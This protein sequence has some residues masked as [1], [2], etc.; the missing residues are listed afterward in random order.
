VKDNENSTV[1]VSLATLARH[2]SD[3]PRGE[4]AALR[5]AFE[6]Q[7][8]SIEARLEPNAYRPAIDATV[9]IISGAFDER[10]EELA[11]ALD[12][13]RVQLVDLQEQLKR[14]QQEAKELAAE[15][16]ELQRKLKDVTSAKTI[17]ETQYQQLV[18]ASQQLT[19]GLS[20]ALH[21]QREQ[22]RPV[23]PPVP[24]RSESIA[25]DV[26]PVK[27]MPSVAAAAAGAKKKPLQFS[28]TARDAK[29]VKIRRG[30]HLSVDGIPGELVDLSLGGAQA[31]LR[32]MVK[33]NQLVRMILPTPT[34]QLVCR[35]RI[36]WVVYE[37]PGTSLS[38]YRMGVKFTDIDTKAVEDFMRDFREVSLSESEQSSDIA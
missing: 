7:I 38:V 3:T 21:A 2:I 29:R 10:I 25:E 18:T 6:R 15:R 22:I 27:R 4:L 12:T 13:S 26:A 24:K 30:T 35:A 37:Q 28:Q 5:A 9:K 14:S 20:R 36:V 31:V 8:S 17:V 1:S 34:G 19:D 32:Q 23:T 16:S 11:D 33:P